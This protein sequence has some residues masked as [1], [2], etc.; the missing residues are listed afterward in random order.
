M[1]QTKSTPSLKARV[2]GHKRLFALI[3]HAKHAPYPILTGWMALCHRLF[4][5][6]GN[7][8]VFSSYDG[9]LY[10]DNPRAVA[11]ALHAA[12]PQAKLVFRLNRRGMAM[13]APDYIEKIP[14][15]TARTLME[16]ATARVIVTN[17]TMKIWMKKF[18]DQLYVQTWHGDRG[19][20]RV[21]LD[22]DPNRRFFR[23]EAAR[24]DVA[25][26]GSRFATGVFKSA[27]AVK[28]E[29]LECGC[30]RNDLLVKNPPEV[31]S[32]VRAALGIPEG[33]KVVMYAP[34]FRVGSSGSVQD[35]HLSLEKVRSTLERTTGEK[36]LCITRGHVDSRGVRSDA[37]MDVSDW[38]ETAELLLMTDLVITDYSSIGGDFMLLDRPV[39]FYQPDIG[40]YN[41]ER[42]LYFDPD[43]SPLIVAHSEKELLEILSA[44]IDGPGNCKKVLDF[45]GCCETGRAAQAV[46]ERVKRE[47]RVESEEWR[48]ERR[49]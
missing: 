42:G 18:P 34:T 38:P 7:K 23:K 45:F 27:F 33:V 36:W 35:A 30:P 26:S 19:F 31:A 12:C 22:A 46:A 20:K 48:V 10:N 11:E 6:D 40:D 4:G 49:K 21:Q 47:L 14:R 2:K 24:I 5:V 44:P 15:F 37:A 3:Q 8:V 1:A 39:I 16:L 13:D 41:A 17:A 28:K 32:H 9:A 29:I 43:Q 25:V